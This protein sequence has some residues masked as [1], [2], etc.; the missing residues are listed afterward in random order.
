MDPL[1]SFGQAATLT[2]LELSYTNSGIVWPRPGDWFRIGSLQTGFEQRGRLNAQGQ[3]ENLILAPDEYYL[4]SYYDPELSRAGAAIFRSANNGVETFI[5]SAILHA[6][7][8]AVAGDSDGDGLSDMEEHIVGTSADLADTDGDGISDR[9]ELV[10]NSNPLDGQPAAVGAV[11]TVPTLGRARAISVDGDLA[12]VRSG[13]TEGVSWF[14]V[15]QPDHPLRIGNQ[16]FPTA[17]RPLVALT[18]RWGVF[19][20]AG[21]RIFTI[22]DLSSPAGQ[23]GLREVRVKI[24]PVTLAASGDYAWVG[25]GSLF[26]VD[27]KT[28]AVVSSRSYSGGAIDHVVVAEGFVYLI[29]NGLAH[30]SQAGFE[31]VTG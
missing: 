13:S 19:A 26:L 28:G 20:S 29:C 5:P 25:S 24:I 6:G 21:G 15:R 18:H 1:A 4:V 17:Q 7:L 12:L 31:R 14:D 27:L 16:A 23:I 2:E 11:A 3:I 8:I 9:L 22:L 30:R 10:A